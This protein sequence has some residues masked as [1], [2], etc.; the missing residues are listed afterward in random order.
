VDVFFEFHV[1]VT[2]TRTLFTTARWATFN[3][4]EAE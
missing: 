4:V 2:D 1:R 3:L